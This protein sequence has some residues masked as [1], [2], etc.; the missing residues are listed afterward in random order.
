[1]PRARRYIEIEGQFAR[2]VLGAFDIIRGFATL[3]EL[4]EISRAY[5]MTDGAER[6]RVAGHQREVDE[7]H[8]QEI[9]DYLERGDRQFSQTSAW[10]PGSRCGIMTS[11]ALSSF[12]SRSR[13]RSGYA[14]I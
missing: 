8:A 10:R 5:V 11:D 6:G 3:Q 13:A 7:T 1:M 14:L 4:A 2:H 9:K 12:S